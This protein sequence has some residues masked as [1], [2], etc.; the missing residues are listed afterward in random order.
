M[1][2]Q[3]G[4]ATGERLLVRGPGEWALRGRQASRVSLLGALIVAVFWRGGVSHGAVGLVLLLAIVGWA[5]SFAFRPHRLPKAEFGWLYVALGLYTAL[6]TLPMPRALVELLHPRAVTIH[7]AGRIALGMAPAA[8]MPIAVAAADAALQATLYLVCGV[9]GVTWATILMQADGRHESQGLKHTIVWV[10]TLSGIAWLFGYW[11]SLAWRLPGDVVELFQLVS[12]RNPNHQ[13]GVMNVGLALAFATSL[14]Q[15]AM[16][17]ISLQ[18]LAAFN[19]FVCLMT[20]SRGGIISAAFVTMLVLAFRPRPKEIRRSEGVRELERIQRVVLSSLSV[21]IVLV[22]LAMPV[23]EREFGLAAG[24]T[25]DIS[26]LQVFARTPELLQQGWLFGQAPGTVPV[27]AGMKGSFGMYRLDFLENIIADRLVGGGLWGGVTFLLALAWFAGRLLVRIDQSAHFPAMMAFC[28]LLLQNL[29]DFSMEVAGGLVLFV[30]TATISSRLLRH[31]RPESDEERAAVRQKALRLHKVSVAMSGGAL[32]LAVFTWQASSGVLTRDIGPTLEEASIAETRALVAKHFLYDHHAFYTLG[33]KLLDA[34]QPGPAITA[35]DQALALRPQSEHAKLGRMV[36]RIAA[37]DIDAAAKDA[38][39]L[40]QMPK[41]EPEIMA[42]RRA[43]DVLGKVERGDEVLLQAI[44]SLTEPSYLLGQRLFATRPALVERLALKLRET[45]PARRFPIE[46]LRGSLYVRRKLFEP[47]SRISA[48]LMSDAS[49]EL[50]GWVLE[51]EILAHQGRPYEAHH[52]F[53][54]VC[55]RDPQHPTACAGAVATI[56]AA[57]RPQT[58]L[59]YL[60]S[61]YP[62]MREHPISA[63]RYW[64]AKSDV[65]HQ[66]GNVPEAVA[67][68]RRALGFRR[69]DRQALSKLV[70]LQVEM[71]DRY[72]AQNTIN[73]LAQ[74]TKDRDAD[75]LYVELSQAVTQMSR[76]ITP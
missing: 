9:I 44:T 26:K 22:M 19:G 11:D 34:K 76:A 14:R 58:A 25:Q 5:G 74:T 42:F 7:D 70:R 64:L 39:Q 4:A 46:G 49:T 53:S 75:P 24:T 32:L 52:L 31:R 1:S 12:F 48:V 59:A 54:E 45:F 67:S 51:A 13:A 35:M 23:L 63:H 38:V 8:A 60:Q 27:V 28:A 41:S 61:Q 37:G 36:A 30:M 2:G 33:R 65:Y 71:G 57:N 10:T 56:V 55:R 66:M 6:Q 72:A 43:V 62:R 21:V 29:V 68:A 20:G 15:P 50:A 3:A 18:Y 16:G 69:N 17:L 40:L 73:R 47:A